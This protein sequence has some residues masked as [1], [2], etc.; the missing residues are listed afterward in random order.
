MT[1]EEMIQSETR[2]SRAQ[3]KKLS[4]RIRQVAQ[5]MLQDEDIHLVQQWRKQCVPLT[6]QCFRLVSKC[7]DGIDGSVA[8]F[9]MKRVESIIQ[10][11]QRNGRSFNLSTLDD[12]GG[13]R[14][15]V[16][17]VED[18]YEATHQLTELLNA[19]SEEE[20][21][22]TVKDYIEDPKP[23]G[24]RSCH[25]RVRYP[26]REGPNRVEI[27]VRTK[28][29]RYWATAVEIFDELYGSSIKSPRG[30]E[31]DSYNP[32]VSD[33]K[34]LLE[35]TSDLFSLEEGRP[36]VLEPRFRRGELLM[37]LLQI[38]HLDL[39]LTQL[40]VAYRDVSVR[41]T[42]NQNT[43]VFHILRFLKDSQ[44]LY[45]TSYE[46]ERFEE[47]LQQYDRFE[48]NTQHDPHEPT[49]CEL[50]T[51]EDPPRNS[52]NVVLVRANKDTLDIAYPNYSAQARLFLQKVKE[53]R[54]EAVMSDDHA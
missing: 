9:R 31:N 50:D 32:I 23:G 4:E 21:T 37:P 35:V 29:Q 17:T 46:H 1:Q 24:Y 45:V 22:V 49:S 39:I 41:K 51:I 34:R 3:A 30:D 27:Q 54:R 44:L 36:E 20:V 12:V 15:I 52:T 38:Q 8:T 2:V 10:K 26:G 43:G 18:V 11:I 47:A 14:L 19:T 5:P 42:G 6:R 48:Q 53:Y 13:C 7:A 25:L 33:C 28:L 40:E 16:D